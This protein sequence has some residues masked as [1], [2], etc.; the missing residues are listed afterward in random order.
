MKKIRWGII[1]C[2]AVT[3]RKSGPGFQKSKD[4]ELIAVMRRNAKLAKDYA[5]RL[6][7]PRWYD[8]AYSLIHDQDINAVYIATPPSSHKEYAIAVIEAGKPVYIE[9]P[10]ALNYS[11]CRDILKA[12]KHN[13]VPIFTA[14]YRRALPRFIKIKNLIE[15]GH[16]GIVKEIIIRLHRKPSIEDIKG[17]KHWRVD[18]R[19][20]GNGY[21]FDLGSHMLDLV[22]YF[23][24]PIKFASGY[25][26]NQGQL[27]EADDLV[28]ATY[29][30]ESGAR[31][32]GLWS[33]YAHENL[34][35]TEISGS[36]GKIVYSTFT[37]TPVLLDGGDKVEEYHI[38]NPE[39]VQQPL[40]QTIVDQLLGRRKCPSTGLTGAK[41]NWV[42]DQII[43]VNR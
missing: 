24:G 7:V 12:G 11:E 25:S 21:F 28:G 18:P 29:E 15:G 23:L 1:G 39:H 26:I 32:V 27:Y 9:K 10:M 8:D 40:I 34:D 35:Q 4:S 20:G 22:Q 5:Q 17:V 37:E 38:Q 33:F 6:K 3:E 41:T 2:G 13:K 43:K 14:Y 30:F 42:M 36:K 19:I 16:I 31:G